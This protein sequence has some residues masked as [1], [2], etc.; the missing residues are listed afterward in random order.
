MKRIIQRQLARKGFYNLTT[1]ERLV[2]NQKCFRE[3]FCSSK[4]DPK[5]EKE[6]LY[7]MRT[8]PSQGNVPFYKETISKVCRTKG[9]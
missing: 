6:A 8:R 3:L 2:Q 5:A 7:D 1:E 9:E 4:G